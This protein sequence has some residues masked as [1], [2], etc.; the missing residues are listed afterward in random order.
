MTLLTPRITE[1]DNPLQQSRMN[2]FMQDILAL[3]FR[4]TFLD[5]NG[6][7]ANG[8]K[9]YN[10]DAVWVAYVSNGS[11]DTEDTVAHNLGRI[12]NDIWV[13]IPDKEA[14]VYRGGTTFTRTNLFLKASA[15][16]VTV[17]ILVF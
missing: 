8:L 1:W 10:F 12:P 16:S 6:A 2:Q 14:V 3:S 7:V 5:K 13:G 4:L 11:A 9:S 17:N 15:A